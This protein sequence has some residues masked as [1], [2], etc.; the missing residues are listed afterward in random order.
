MKP[1]LPAA[2]ADR[3]ALHSGL[4]LG[5]RGAAARDR[6]EPASA[7]MPEAGDARRHPGSSSSAPSF[8]EAPTAP[9]S[10]AASNAA[11]G[12]ASSPSPAG[13]SLQ[14]SGSSRGS[15]GAAPSASPGYAG[16]KK[17]PGLPV[18]GPLEA[19]KDAPARASP[20]R[21][22]RAAL[23]SADFSALEQHIEDLTLEKFTLER[24]LASAH[25]VAESLARENS[26][27]TEDFNAQVSPG[28]PCPDCHTARAVSYPTTG[29]PP[30]HS[31]RPAGPSAP[32][33]WHWLEEGYK[34]PGSES[35]AL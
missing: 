18:L 33:T 24:A 2:P 22:G 29:A 31:V 5:E 21:G 23:A 25:L 4:A 27:L 34:E 30:A 12:P 16:E 3:V 35:L 9:Q 26:A 7:P 20:A 32:Q 10:S 19:A 1:P 6:W 15:T 13:A 8:R 28:Q 17:F 14:R 11:A